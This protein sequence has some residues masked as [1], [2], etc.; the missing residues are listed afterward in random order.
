MHRSYSPC[1]GVFAS[2]ISLS[3][4]RTPKTK[5]LPHSHSPFPWRRP[6]AN[7]VIKEVKNS[8]LFFVFGI[9]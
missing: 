8:A 1:T 7:G 2:Q 4:V 6:A 3:G 9:L 5:F